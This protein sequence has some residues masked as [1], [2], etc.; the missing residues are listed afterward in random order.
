MLIISRSDGRV[1]IQIYY[2]A[3][4]YGITSKVN[5][6]P[7]GPVVREAINLIHINDRTDGRTDSQQ[8]STMY[9]NLSIYLFFK[10]WRFCDNFLNALF[11][12][13]LLNDIN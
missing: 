13:I 1:S 12:S 5:A 11:L 6:M 4:S 10:N 8:I 2:Y 9:F 3:F 7:I